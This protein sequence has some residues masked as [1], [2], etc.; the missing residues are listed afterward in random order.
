[1]A[2]GSYSAKPKPT[3]AFNRLN[4]LNMKVSLRCMHMH[5]TPPT[6]SLIC[7][8]QAKSREIGLQH[9]GVYVKATAA[10]VPASIPTAISLTLGSPTNFEY[11]SNYPI[12]SLC[13]ISASTSC[14]TTWTWPPM[15]DVRSSILSLDLFVFW[16]CMK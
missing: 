14:S 10:N 7:L 12:L 13:S 9:D 2:H 3:R 11:W 4:T 15:S 1:M 8:A 6:P 16:R 5:V